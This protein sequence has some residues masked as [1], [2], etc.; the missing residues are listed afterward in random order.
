VNTL[1]SAHVPTDLKLAIVFT[2]LGGGG[3]KNLD[4]ETLT[5]QF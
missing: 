3:G 4:I 1:T 5:Q 2:L